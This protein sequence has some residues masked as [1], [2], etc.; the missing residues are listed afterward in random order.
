MLFA[1][2]LV[3]LQPG[4]VSAGDGSVLYQ[5]SDINLEI[6]MDPDLIC[7]TRNVTSNNAHLDLIGVDNIEELKS[8]MKINHIYLEAV[9]ED[10]AYE[11]IINGKDAD[12]NAKDLNQLSDDELQK[13]FEAYVSSCDNI[14]NSSVT[15]KVTDSS[16]F[17][18]E[19]ATYFVT[20]VTSVSNNNMTIYLRKYYTVMMGKVV[21]FTVQS[22]G[23]QI[24]EMT[25]LKIQS[26][27]DTADYKSIKKSIWENETLVEIGSSVITLLVP[28]AILALIVFVV[29]RST[30]KTKKQIAAEEERLRKKK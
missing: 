17:K 9:P 22:N 5:F 23:T 11:F 14:D 6:Q 18:S 29:Y 10:V 30:K 16:I 28:I 24:T 12:S 7:F 2:M 26:M 3:L 21:T 25:G 27:V 20:D 1:C 8:L 15:E 4:I 19:R 13:E